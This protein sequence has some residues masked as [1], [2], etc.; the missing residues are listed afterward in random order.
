MNLAYLPAASI[1][2]RL[3][4]E[5]VFLSLGCFNVCVRSHLRPF[6]EAFR[7]FYA[8]YPL[9]QESGFVDYR[10]ELDSPGLLRSWIRPQVNFMFDGLRPFKPLPKEQAFAMFEWGLNWVVAQHAHQFLIIH[11]AVV[12][13]QGRALLLPGSPGSGKSTLCA[14]LVSRGWR[15]LSD[16]MALVSR[17]NGLIMP[18]PRPISL[19]NASIGIIRAYAESAQIGDVVYDTAKGS[20]AH[21]RVSG[22][23]LEL[24]TQPA[25]PA[26]LVFPKWQADAEG[27]IEAMAKGRALL[28]VAENSFNYNVLGPEGFDV[29]ADTIDKCR[30]YTY[31]YSSLDDAVLAMER[32][33]DDA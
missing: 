12:E 3:R 26:C 7:F 8:D 16:E 24:A 9:C 32:T 23:C 30:C 20:V 1:H 33:L 14:A 19:K 2:S 21:M 15:L 18:F 13:R 29:L 4:E 25:K 17:D 27:R 10:V 5:G 22:R 11:A 28:A 31:T 6:A